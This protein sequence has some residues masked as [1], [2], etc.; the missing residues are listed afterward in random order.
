[1][2]NVSPIVKSFALEEAA[3]NNGGGAWSMILM[4]MEE[5]VKVVLLTRKKETGM[6][7][8]FKTAEE[9]AVY[10]LLCP[11]VGQTDGRCWEMKMG[12]CL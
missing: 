1:M 11:A 12:M 7:L 10:L 3:A 4:V 6:G 8:F 2:L 5:Q 9:Q